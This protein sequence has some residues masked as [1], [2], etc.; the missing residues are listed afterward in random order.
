[1]K[2]LIIP[3]DF[4]EMPAFFL[5]GKF[6]V[7]V[8]IPLVTGLF[9]LKVAGVIGRT[10]K[11]FAAA[12]GDH[13]RHR[14]VV[15]EIQGRHVRECGHAL[16]IVEIKREPG[17]DLS[18]IRDTRYPAAGGAGFFNGHHEHSGEDG[19]NPDHYQKFHESKPAEI[20]AR[21]KGYPSQVS[22]RM[23]VFD[24]KQLIALAF[25]ISRVVRTLGTLIN[26]TGAFSLR[27]FCAQFSENVQG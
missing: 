16:V 3:H 5:T 19:D 6:A 20:K 23:S 1:M 18:Q 22:L 25:E 26:G 2:W 4:I 21:R 17:A 15:V 24:P 7:L 11:D 10:A 14:Q 8:N 9:I 12:W 13:F 27:F